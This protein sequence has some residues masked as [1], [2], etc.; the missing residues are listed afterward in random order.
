MRALPNLDPLLLSEAR[1]R[2]ITLLKGLYYEFFKTN[3]CS[4]DAFLVLNASANWD[5]DKTTDPMN[6][7]EYISNTFY[8]PQ[9]VTAFMNLQ[10]VKCFGNLIK[11]TIFNHITHSYDIV[12]VYVEVQKKACCIAKKV[13]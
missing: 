3:Q 7:W 1:D 2:Y 5:L 11:K 4:G 12:S 10:H 9:Y 8:K 13:K 6:S